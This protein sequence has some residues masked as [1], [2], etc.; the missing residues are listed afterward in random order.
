MDFLKQYLSRADEI[1]GE[2]TPDEGGLLVRREDSSN[3]MNLHQALTDYANQNAG[4]D[5]DLDLDLEAAA[6]DHLLSA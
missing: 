2:R 3:R 5:A 4:T 6:T 1:I